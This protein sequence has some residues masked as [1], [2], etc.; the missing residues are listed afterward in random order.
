M[1][2]ET[3]SEE[4]NSEMLLIKSIDDIVLKLK[5]ILIYMKVSINLGSSANLIIQNFKNYFQHLL[6]KRRVLIKSII[7]TRKKAAIFIQSKLRGFKIQK[8]AKAILKLLQS[9]FC[10]ES[11]IKNVS[12]L[13]LRIYLSL[14]MTQN[15]DF[16]YCKI[17]K[18][19]VLYIPR[20]LI[21]KHSIK[22]NFIADGKIFIDPNYR[23]D[24]DGSGSFYNIIE[25]KKFVEAEEDKK[26]YI[27]M[28]T[29]QLHY[30]LKDINKNNISSSD[31]DETDDMKNPSKGSLLTLQSK[32]TQSYFRTSSHMEIKL[33]DSIQKSFH[34]VNTISNL[35]MPKPIL[36]S[37]S[38]QSSLNK[39]KKVSFT[40]IM[41]YDY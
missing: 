11:M 17:R 26:E 19:Y 40:N 34:R 39:L 30:R 23:T 27:E 25:F 22:V 5:E 8:L 13:T 16:Q 6:N 21:T 7:E 35:R 14:G 2:I 15:I 9:N 4:I 24:Y 33:K 12:I 38:S 10:L 32:K 31:D 18:T 36:K 37:P 3:I 28:V 41:T 29:K 1:F 20:E